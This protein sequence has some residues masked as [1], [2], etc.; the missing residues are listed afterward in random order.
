[1]NLHYSQT[2]K[3]KKETGLKFDYSMNLHY[4][5]TAFQSLCNTRLFDYSM[6]LHYSQTSN[7]KS[8]F[9]KTV[10]HTAEV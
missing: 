10:L 7:P 4:S 3:Y 5:Q 6:N 2:D 8:P 1:M 9:E